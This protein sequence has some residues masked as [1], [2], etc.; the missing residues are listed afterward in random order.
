M[1]EEKRCGSMYGKNASWEG[2]RTC[3]EMMGKIL[4]EKMWRGLVK[5]DREIEKSGVVEWKDA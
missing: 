2:K 3:Q 4:G 5:W 1:E